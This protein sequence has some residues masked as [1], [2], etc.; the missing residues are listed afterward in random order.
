MVLSGPLV[1]GNAVVSVFFAAIGGF[2]ALLGLAMLFA[3][4]STFREWFRVRGTPTSTARG[5]AVGQV[6]VEG[7][8]SAAG[9]PPVS[10]L[11]RTDCAYAC[12]EVSERSGDSWSPVETG[13][14]AGRLLLEDE[15]GAV[16]VADPGNPFGH[17]TADDRPAPSVG[18]QRAQRGGEERTE[19]T[20]RY[21]STDEAGNTH[22]AVVFVSEDRVETTTVSAGEEPP[23]EVRAL[24]E[25]A[26]L[27]PVASGR[28]RY[29][30]FVVPEGE[31]V[32]V[33]GQAVPRDDDVDGPDLVV[34]GDEARRQFLLADRGED[35]FVELL[36]W[37]WKG[38]AFMG[39][40]FT[41][42]GL[43]VFLAG[44]GTF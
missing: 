38:I 23:R 36:R 15:T 8:V 35:E 12:W 40:L 31:T 22:R 39:S 42:I 25:A 32:Y 20:I 28:R 30:E 11:T 37:R 34:E 33:H 9:D 41:V 5:A 26:G 18:H 3:K 6:D 24:C 43:L 14:R 13:D 19:Y 44:V 2:F 4:I 21:R 16:L 17:A 7:T 27:D 29:R 1:T 10:P